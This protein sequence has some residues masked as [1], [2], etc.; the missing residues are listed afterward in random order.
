MSLN[1][2]D[3][4]SG[5]NWTLFNGDCVEVMRGMPEASIHLTITSPPYLQLFNYSP[6]PRDVSNCKS[7]EQFWEHFTIVIEELYRITKPGRIAV[8]DVMNVPSLKHRDGAIYTKDFRG[9]VIRAM[10]TAGFLFHSETLCWKDPL[11]E[12]VR[13][14][15]LGLMHQQLCKDSSM[16]RAGLPQYLLAFRKQGQNAEP[17]V[18]ENG[19]DYFIGENPPT[20]GNLSHERWR[21]LASPVWMD[22]N[23]MRTLNARAAREEEDERHLCPMA[24]DMIERAL[25]LWSNPGDVCFDPFSGVGSTGFCALQAGR[26]SCG[27]ELKPAYWKQ[28][29]SNL[30]AASTPKQVDLFQALEDAHG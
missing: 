8:M 24:L 23:F 16:S 26:K 14:K 20:T 5:E 25:Q 10:Q 19:L 4:A 2:L 13:T 21:R 1:V 30:K 3:Q 15:T 17:I 11:L 9:D 12:A 6:S 29:V 18:H 27:V 7:D 22:V 28:A